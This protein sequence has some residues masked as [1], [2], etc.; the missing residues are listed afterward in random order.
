[1][2]HY[3]MLVIRFTRILGLYKGTAGLMKLA[4]T[5]PFKT[6]SN[7]IRITLADYHGTQKIAPV[8]HSCV[9]FKTIQSRFRSGFL[10][11]TGSGT[12]F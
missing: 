5:L 10:V 4:H 6:R 1:M 3:I 7:L 12:G 8:V 9:P 11:H 2:L